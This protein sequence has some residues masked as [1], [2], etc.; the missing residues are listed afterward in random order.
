MLLPTSIVL[1]VIGV[2]RT[3]VTHLGQYGLPSVLP[4]VFYAGLLMLVASAVIELAQKNLSRV[5]MAL[6]AVTLVMMLYG[7]APLVYQEG[8]Y[9]W[10]YKTIGV[11][12]YVN[13]HGDLDRS[14]D[15][16]QNW[17]GFFAFAAWF[18]KSRAFRARSSTR[19]GRNL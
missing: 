19:S 16:Y 17:P 2:S 11:V 13:A 14:I 4:I 15:I 6:H 10:L 3:N 7:T 18:E 5:R 8:R 12:Q 1:W 9:S